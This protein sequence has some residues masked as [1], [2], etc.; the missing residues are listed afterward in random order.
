MGE[1]DLVMEAL[2]VG[3]AFA[4]LAV[5]HPEL[6]GQCVDADRAIEGLASADRVR[7]TKSAASTG[8]GWVTWSTI[9]SAM[10]QVGP[11]D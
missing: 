11:D 4:R 9:R 10:N 7:N 1:L 2:L 3:H 5:F 6:R 8:S